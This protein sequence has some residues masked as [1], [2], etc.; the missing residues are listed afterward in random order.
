MKETKFTTYE[1]KSFIIDAIHELGFYEPTDIQKRIIPAVLK[2]ES[3]I[4]QS[5]TGQG[6][7]MRIYCRL[8]IQL[9]QAKSKY[10]WSLLH[11]HEN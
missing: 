5:Q 8:F 10:K 4:G 3:V 2:G 7:P 9:I 6:K 1:L 11:Q